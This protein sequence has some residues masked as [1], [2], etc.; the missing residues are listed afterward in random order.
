MPI[1]IKISSSTNDI[2]MVNGAIALVDDGEKLAQDIRTRLKTAR[3]EAILDRLYGF[4]YGELF[5]TKK[6]NLSEVET[7]IKQYIVETN[8]VKRITQFFLDYAGGNQ[9]KL[10]VT[11]SVEATAGYLI[12]N[13]EVEI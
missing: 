11:F 10:T 7:L 1:G 12:S 13:I 8:G 3:G 5:Q 2:E 4:P 9:R 6:I